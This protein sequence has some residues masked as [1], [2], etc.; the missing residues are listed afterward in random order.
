MYK[1]HI[2]AIEEQIAR[3]KGQGSHIDLKVEM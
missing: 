2:Q 1:K 3:A